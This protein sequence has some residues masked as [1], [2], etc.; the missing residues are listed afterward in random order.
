MIGEEKEVGC[1][2]PLRDQYN[3]ELGWLYSKQQH[4]AA[5]FYDCANHP[6][7]EGPGWTVLAKLHAHNNC[8]Q[9]HSL[10]LHQGPQHLGVGGKAGLH[11]FGQALVG[12]VFLAEELE[13][14]IGFWS[15][16]Q[17]SRPAMMPLPGPLT[18]PQLLSP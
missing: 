11:C 15:V 16:S 17:I 2:L 5:V 6:A 7:S 13:Q 10:V 18:L 12:R 9:R 3:Q 8:M 4:R 1:V 14:G